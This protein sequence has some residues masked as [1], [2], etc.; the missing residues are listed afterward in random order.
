MAPKVDQKMALKKVTH[1]GRH[2]D[3]VLQIYRPYCPQLVV[4]IQRHHFKV[5]A[6]QSH[7]FVAVLQDSFD[8]FN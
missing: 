2:L 3:L 7:Y 5:A 8:S 1:Q 6:D 4:L